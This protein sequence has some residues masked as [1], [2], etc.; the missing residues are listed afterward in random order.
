MI[1]RFLNHFE[2]FCFSRSVDC[3][4]TNIE[5]MIEGSEKCIYR[6]LGFKG[7]SVLYDIERHSKDKFPKASLNTVHC[8]TELK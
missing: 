3:Q 1:G 4:C 6:Y 8:Y 2:G 7:D 5:I